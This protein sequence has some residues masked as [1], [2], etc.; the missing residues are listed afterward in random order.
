MLSKNIENAIFEF[1]IYI[2]KNQYENISLQAILV[3]KIFEE[4]KKSEI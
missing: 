3:K 2:P 4:V 1:P